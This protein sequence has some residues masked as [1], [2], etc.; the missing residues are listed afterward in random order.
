MSSCPYPLFDDG[1]LVLYVPVCVGAL[2]CGLGTLNCGFGVIGFTDG[3]LKSNAGAASFSST[4][5]FFLNGVVVAT[6]SSRPVAITVI[7][8]SSGYE[9][10]Y[11]APKIISA[12]SPVR[13]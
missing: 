8:H 5:A 7:L 1:A 6:D 3:F 12:S 13:S 11:L 10:S 2:V 4:T 9:S